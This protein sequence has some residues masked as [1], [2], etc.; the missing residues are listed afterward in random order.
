MA[1]S[2]VIEKTFRDDDMMRLFNQMIGNSEPDPAVVIPKIQ[3]IQAAGDTILKVLESWRISP[4]GKILEAH[5]PRDM[6]EVGEFVTRGRRVLAEHQLENNDRVLTNLA[7]LNRNR[8][9]LNKFLLS[10]NIEYITEGL[11]AKY[12]SLEG[13]TLIQNSVMTL[14]L[15]KGALMEEQTRARGT[16]PEEPKAAVS[17]ASAAAVSASGVVASLALKAAAASPALKAA[18]SPAPAASPAAPHH[19][20]QLQNAM[21]AVPKHCL[22]DKAS[23]S[24]AFVVNSVGD[25][26]QL[27]SFSRL[28]FKQIYLRGLLD[29]RLTDYLL[30]VLFL[31]HRELH[32]IVECITRP[33]VNVEELGQV[34]IS[35]IESIKGQLPGCEKA[36]KRISD[37]LDLFKSNFNGYYKDF[38]SAKSN[39]WVILESYIHDVADTNSEDRAAVAQFGKIIKFYNERMKVTGNKDPVMAKMMQKAQEQ[40]QLLEG[41]AAKKEARPVAVAAK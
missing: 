4:C 30:H 15:L 1:S 27:F 21:P 28:D 26:L 14:K 23:L 33:N 31:V 39:P 12:K 32:K 38:L 18:A 25:S 8:E 40:M 22:E 34:I 11:G 17:A 5:F 29:A 10:A 13:S 37:S 16:L 7:S 41:S 20:L 9:E 6:A 35:S 19:V 36:F 3:E 2:K 24:L